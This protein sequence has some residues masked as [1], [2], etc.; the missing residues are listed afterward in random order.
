MLRREPM[1]SSRIF[2]W[3]HFTRLTR[4]E[5]LEAIPLSP[6]LGRRRPRR[7]H[8]RRQPRR[9][10]QLPRLGQLTAHTRTADARTAL[11]GTGAAPPSV[12]VVIDCHERRDPH[13]HCPGRPPPAVRSDHFAPGPG[14]TSDP[15]PKVNGPT[16]T[17]RDE[18]L[19]GWH[20]TPCGR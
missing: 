8:L 12:A 7:H 3:Q 15:D 16:K 14:T 11:A 9:T 18:T 6:H 5:V 1:L 19:T 10:R 20:T 13:A 4:S 2:I 17:V